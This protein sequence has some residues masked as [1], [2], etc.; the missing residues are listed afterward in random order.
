MDRNQCIAD[1]LENMT[2]TKRGMAT[3][4]HQIMQHLPVS[5]VQLELLYIIRQQQPMSSKALADDRQL[6]PGAV[7]QLIEALEVQKLILRKQDVHDRRIQML[8]VTRAGEKI[9]HTVHKRRNELFHTVMQN[10]SDEDLISWQL[11]LQKII[12]EFE[13]QKFGSNAHVSKHSKGKI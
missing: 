5:P 8:R 1:I 7:S 11:I 12:H 9:L 4:I 13:I 2:L 10:F 3:H 6:T